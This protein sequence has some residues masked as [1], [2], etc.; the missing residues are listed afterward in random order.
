METDYLSQRPNE[1]TETAQSEI[2]QIGRSA[3]FG[4][5]IGVVTGELS[6]AALIKHDFAMPFTEALSHRQ[7]EGVGG[8]IGFMLVTGISYG[9]MRAKKSRHR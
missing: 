5:A 4:L 1:A 9:V 2:Q 7:Q 3:I 6:S 8:I